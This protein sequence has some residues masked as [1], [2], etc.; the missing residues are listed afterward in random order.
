MWRYNQKL[1]C[2]FHFIC[3][4]KF[5]MSNSSVG[6]TD[7]NLMSCKKGQTLWHHPESSLHRPLGAYG[8]P[9]FQIYW[10][11]V[12]S[13][14]HWSVEKT[15]K[16]KS[17]NKA[18]NDF[19]SLFPVILHSLQ[20]W[21]TNEQTFS[22]FYTSFSLN[23]NFFASFSVINDSNLKPCSCCLQTMAD[24]TCQEEN[25]TWLSAP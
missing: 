1:L 10:N 22:F 4:S 18:N 2:E 7:C 5:E 23:L 3:K 17:N 8:G 13:R 24:V 25:F 6:T 12:M 20:T 16:K 9:H 15:K 11:N 14:E 21:H 19:N